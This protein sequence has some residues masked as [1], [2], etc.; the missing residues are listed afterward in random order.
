MK[1][2]EDVIMTKAQIFLME[3]SLV[4]VIKKL[5]VLLKKTLKTL[6]EIKNYG[7]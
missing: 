6:K 1:N 2:F 5:T 4:K 7:K 3:A